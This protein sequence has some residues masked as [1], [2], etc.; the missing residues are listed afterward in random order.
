MARKVGADQL[1]I[2]VDATHA[3]RLPKSPMLPEN[4]IDA[5]ESSYEE[6]YET[7]YEVNILPRD[8]LSPGSMSEALKRRHSGYTFVTRE[9][10][11]AERMEIL[12]NFPT[13][14]FDISSWDRDDT[15]F[16]DSELDFIESSTDIRQSILNS[17]DDWRKAVS[18]PVEDAIDENYDEILSALEPKDEYPGE[19]YRGKYKDAI[20]S[21]GPFW[22][23]IVQVCELLE[24]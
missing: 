8:G 9:N 14:D 13:F 6:F 3:E 21:K 16:E 19:E 22:R 17:E 18:D 1:D 20:A 15:V 4:L 23:G 24:D 5:I 12:K 10:T 11:H 2:F 7:E